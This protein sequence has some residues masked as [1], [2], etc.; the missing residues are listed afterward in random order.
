MRQAEK[1]SQVSSGK[2]S[3]S[4]F[5]SD[6]KS[7]QFFQE[8]NVKITKQAHA[9]KGYASF[10]NVEILNS[11]NSELQLKDTESG[12]KGKLLDFLTQLKGFKFITTLALVLKKIENDDKTKHG[13]FYS[14]S[15]A[16]TIIN[17]S[18]IEYVFELMCTTIISDIQKSLGK[19]SGLITDSV[20]EHDI[21]ISQYSLLVGNQLASYI[22]LPK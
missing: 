1:V 18:D 12:I 3:N 2:R 15:K 5:Q 14:H 13:T 16:G 7:E 19:G 9:F 4:S 10:Y 22:K 17:K 20:I 6:N 11:F 8:K 21:N